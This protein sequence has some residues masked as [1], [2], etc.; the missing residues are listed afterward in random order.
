VPSGWIFLL[1]SGPF[2]LEVYSDSMKKITANKRFGVNKEENIV[3]Y[4]KAIVSLVATVFIGL[5]VLYLT[6]MNVALR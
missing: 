4:V 3:L 5:I 6:G 2:L 1:G